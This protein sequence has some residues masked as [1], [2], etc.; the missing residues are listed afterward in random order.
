MRD[1]GNPVIG[2]GRVRRR[3][4]LVVLAVLASAGFAQEGGGTLDEGALRAELA[5]FLALGNG[6]ELDVFAAH[7]EAE[8]GSGPLGLAFTAL[9]AGAGATDR[10]RYHVTARVHDANEPAAAAPTR[11]VLLELER[12]NL[13]PAVRA[14]LVRDLGEEAV[15]SAA[16]FGEG[17][18]VSWRVV[19]RR[20]PGEPGSVAFASRAELGGGTA[21]NCLGAPCLAPEDVI[22]LLAPWSEPSEEPGDGAWEPGRIALRHGLPAPAVVADLAAPAAWLD[23]YGPEVMTGGAVVA[24]LVLE[25]GLAQEAVVEVALRQGDL[26]D[27]SVAAAWRR[28][29]VVADPVAPTLYTAV[30][31]ECRRG[32]GG[33]A[34][35]G[36]LCP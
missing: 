13:G 22:A 28:L 8:P 27:D 21:L 16:E 25:T 30:A 29:V 11:Y 10:A 3:W 24:E 5:H 18:H 31:Y 2:R 4:L 32:G 36:G 6:Y 26:L 17:P 14:E 19:V 34:A 7:P 20:P 12:Y 1:S 9:E 33:F 23:L 15:A 35:P